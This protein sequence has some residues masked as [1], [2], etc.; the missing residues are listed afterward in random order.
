MMESVLYQVRSFIEKWIS[1]RQAIGFHESTLCARFK[2]RNWFRDL[3]K[4]LRKKGKTSLWDI[5]L[6]WTSVLFFGI[7]LKSLQFLLDNHASWNNILHLFFNNKTSGRNFIRIAIWRNKLSMREAKKTMQLEEWR[8]N[9]IQIIQYFNNFEPLKA[10][11]SFSRGRIYNLDE[12][13][14][15]NVPIRCPDMFHSQPEKYSPSYVIKEKEGRE[16]F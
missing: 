2:K 6:S 14:I 10:K 3:Q 15:Q 1:I 16:Y 11:F 4:Y 13:L 5:V 7:I 8:F 9:R 12:M